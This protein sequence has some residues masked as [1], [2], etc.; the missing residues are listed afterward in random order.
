MNRFFLLIFGLLCSTLTFAEVVAGFQIHNVYLNGGKVKI[1]T[2]GSTTVKFDV[3]SSRYLIGGSPEVASIF[4]KLVAFSASNATVIGNLSPLYNI[5]TSDF[6]NDINSPNYMAVKKTYEINIPYTALSNYGNDLRIG[7]VWK[8]IAQTPPN[9]YPN[10]LWHYNPPYQVEL[11]YPVTIENNIISF[12]T[13]FS[14]LE[15]IEIS[16]TTPVVSSGTYTY[17]WDTDGS[18]A[19]VVFSLHPYSSRPPRLTA[20]TSDLNL[21]KISMPVLNFTF[22]NNGT[23]IRRKIIHSSGLISYSNSLNISKPLNSDVITVQILPTS[24]IIGTNPLSTP[25]NM[26]LKAGTMA[27]CEVVNPKPGVKYHWIY[28]HMFGSSGSSFPLPVE[29]DLGTT[30]SF[31]LSSFIHTGR[32]EIVSVIGS[33]GSEGGTGFFLGY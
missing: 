3:T 11:I 23:Y 27:Y 6:S 18:L 31:N 7:L 28:R 26:I 24:Q 19:P 10:G 8:S 25:G 12:S 5:T 9:G 2:V 21:L 30:F 32:P 22:F 4:Y 17:E 20:Q 29:A 15:D 16:G 1:N 13:P 14:Y 33:D